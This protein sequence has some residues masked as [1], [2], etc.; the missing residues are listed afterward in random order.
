MTLTSAI[1]IKVKTERE[2]VEG[3]DGSEIIGRD[4]IS[5]ISDLLRTGE[6]RSE[7]GPKMGR[8]E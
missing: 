8:R 2:G 1:T 7:S 5:G 3:G 4:G 6:G